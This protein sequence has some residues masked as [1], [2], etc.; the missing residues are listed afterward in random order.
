[1]ISFVS[2]ILL[3]I[4]ALVY[5]TNSRDRMLFGSNNCVKILE[6]SDMPVF[7]SRKK[8]RFLTKSCFFGSVVFRVFFRL[9]MKP[10]FSGVFLAK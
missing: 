1:M 9:K 10:K 3:S 8:N 6:I 5:G 2:N 7:L 4:N